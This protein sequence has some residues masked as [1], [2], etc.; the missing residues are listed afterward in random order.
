[1]EYKTS[2]KE[3]ARQKAYYQA[4]KEKCKAA[5]KKYYEEHKAERRA[6][7]LQ[8]SEQNKE[9]LKEYRKEYYKKNR[10]KILS[11]KK[12]YYQKNK[13]KILKKKYQYWREKGK[14][15]G[16]YEYW[17]IYLENGGAEKCE[18]CGSETNLAIHHKDRNHN[19]NNIS[20]LQ[21]LCSSCHT[22]THNELRKL[23]R[24]IQR[25]EAERE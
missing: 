8:F 1:M 7:N 23:D 14:Y 20:N 24:Q 4:N 25:I 13:D 9:T 10:E 3:R 11:D 19:N 17:K 18:K 5:N 2:E 22:R 15:I 21:C 12:E 16:R 6:Y